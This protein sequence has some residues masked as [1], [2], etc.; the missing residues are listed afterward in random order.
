[1]S[2]LTAKDMQL[3]A[4]FLKEFSARLGNDGCNDWEFP[5]DWTESE[6]AQFKLDICEWNNGGET[7][8]DWQSVPNWVAVDILAEKLGMQ[9]E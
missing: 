3:A 8:D 1:M 7:V 4:K 6:T 9:E 2:P 5:S